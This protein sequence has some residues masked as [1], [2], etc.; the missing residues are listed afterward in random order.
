MKNSLDSIVKSE[1][2]HSDLSEA[3]MEHGHQQLG[4]DNN[5]HDVVGADDHGAHEGAQLLRVGDA[6]DEERHVRQGEDVPEEG[7]AGPHEPVKHN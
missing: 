6:G 3:F 1:M 7:V 4:Q 5:N 2:T